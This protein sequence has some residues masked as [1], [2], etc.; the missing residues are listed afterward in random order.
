MTTPVPQG[1][2]AQPAAKPLAEVFSTAVQHIQ[3][4]TLLIQVN[5]EKLDECI[6]ACDVAIERFKWQQQLAEQMSRQPDIGFGESSPHALRSAQQLAQKFK[7][8]ASG[9]QPG[10]NASDVIESHINEVIEI[11][12]MY[13][14]MKDEYNEAERLNVDTF[15]RVAATIHS[16]T[17][18]GQY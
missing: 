3:G 18:T 4:G 1:P 14:A 13:Q 11:K 15:H 9:G 17:S 10:N 8:K 7:D 2:A 6:K 5:D 12:R 16:N